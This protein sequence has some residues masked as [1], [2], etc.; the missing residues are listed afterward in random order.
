MIMMKMKMNCLL[1]L[2]A[3]FA[4]WG[5]AACDDDAAKVWNELPDPIAKF[6][7]EYWPGSF[8]RSYTHDDDGYTVQI[9]NG[10]QIVFDTGYQWT[11]IDGKGLPLPQQLLFDQLPAA[12]YDYLESGEYL[13]QVFGVGRDARQ[14]TVELLD[15]ELVY[16]IATGTVRSAT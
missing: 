1:V 13:N 15:Q 14:Y 8:A 4:A 9:A 10:P 5:L 16:T 2:A 12:L 6:I 11:G 3:L 7:D